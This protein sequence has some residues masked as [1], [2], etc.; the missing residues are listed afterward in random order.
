MKEETSIDGPFWDE[1]FCSGKLGLVRYCEGRGSV[2]KQGGG[3][4][5]GEARTRVVA[6]INRLG[7][8]QALVTTPSLAP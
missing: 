7:L 8:L 4:E 2:R 6:Q 5:G 3:G 1:T